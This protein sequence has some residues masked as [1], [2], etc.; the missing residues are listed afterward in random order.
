L[1]HLQGLAS[2]VKVGDGVGF[3]S[4]FLRRAG[5]PVGR[6]GVALCN[7]RFSQGAS[8][9]VGGTVLCFNINPFF[10]KK[11]VTRRLGQIGSEFCFWSRQLILVVLDYLCNKI[12]E[13]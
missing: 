11:K 13:W 6:F 8:C 5:A 10:R 1:R 7:S 9:K 3:A 12:C 2:L 4:S